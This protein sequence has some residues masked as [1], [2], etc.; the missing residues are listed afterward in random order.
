MVLH[1]G[2]G[3]VK[4]LLTMDEC[5]EVLDDLFQQEARGQA[6]NTPT[7]EFHLPGAGFLRLKAG[8]IDGSDC[9]GFK[10]YSPRGRRLVFVYDL[11]AEL[12]GIVDA[13]HLTQVRTGAMSAVATRYMARPGSATLG[14][15]GTGKEARTQVEALSR[16]LKLQ[17]VK[18]YS[19]NPENRERFAKEMSQRLELNVEPVDTPEA[20]IKDVDVVV[21]ATSANTPILP[22]AWLQPGMH[23]NAIG[24]TGMF[25]R[26]LDED[27][28]L[29]A[30]IVVVE[31]LPQAQAEIGELI[32]LAQRGKLRWSAV[33]ELR[34]VVSGAIPGRSHPEDLTLFDSIGVGTED[35]AVAAHLIRKAR[36][37]RMGTELAM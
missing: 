24:A 29:R 10:T 15:M 18:A 4:E 1:L 33:R 3:L 22:G 11:Q 20:S 9:L 31:H 32:H 35:V 6:E 23:V 2:E 16:V 25:R 30:A 21:T 5:I 7:T 36:A 28:I 8:L 14:I 12:Q 34:D 27:A 13:I 17:Q 19:R 37:A 26:E